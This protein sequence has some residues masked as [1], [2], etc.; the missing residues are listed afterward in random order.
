MPSNW[1][2]KW[3]LQVK[4]Q[5]FQGIMLALRMAKPRNG[6]N[7]VADT[8]IQVCPKNPMNFNVKHVQVAK[9]LGRGLHDCSMVQ[10]MVLKSDAVGTIKHVER[11]LIEVF[12]TN[13]DT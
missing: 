5:G 1:L 10:D 4:G 8:C 2:E 11:V 13:V 6:K 7:S 9:L 12:G 3:I